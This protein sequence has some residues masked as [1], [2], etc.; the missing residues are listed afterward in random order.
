MQEQVKSMEEEKETIQASIRDSQSLSIFQLTSKLEQLQNEVAKTQ[1]YHHYP[2]IAT[3]L[4][5]PEY[6]SFKGMLEGLNKTVL[7]FR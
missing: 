6:F 3:V 2:D 7:R 1:V 4:Y 5:S